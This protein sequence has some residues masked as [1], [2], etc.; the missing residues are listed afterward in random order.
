MQY[1]CY[2]WPSQLWYFGNPTAGP[3]YVL[4]NGGSGEVMDVEGANVNPYTP[5]DEW[6]YNNGDNQWFWLTAGTNI[7]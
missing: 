6:S 7:S 3:E 4:T 2:N 1:P 5:L